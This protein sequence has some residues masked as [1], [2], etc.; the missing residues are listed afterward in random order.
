[1]GEHRLRGL[2]RAGL[3]FG[4][5]AALAQCPT[6]A[7]NALVKRHLVQPQNV[8]RRS[9]PNLFLTVLKQQTKNLYAKYSVQEEDQWR[10]GKPRAKLHQ[11][12]ESRKFD[13]IA[14]DRAKS[15]VKF[16]A[17]TKIPKKARL[18]QGN[19]NE[20][21]AYERPEEYA[22]MSKTLQA[23]GDTTFKHAGITFQFR[24]AGGMNHD[25]LSDQFT[26]W[27]SMPGKKLID[28]R[29]GSNWDATMQE[30][31]LISEARVYEMLRMCSAPR[32][33]DRCRGVLGKI[34]AKKN[35]I[36]RVV[37]QY[38]TRWKRL[39]GD[40]NTS[41]GNTIISM[42]IAFVVLTELPI[43]MRPTFVGAFFMGD[44]Y[45]A[46]MAF[47]SEPDA[48][49]LANA[50]NHGESAMGITPVR[51]IFRDP[52]KVTFIS[53]G[54]W[55]RFDGGYQFVPQ[56]AKQLTKLF[57]TVKRL[58][59]KEIPNYQS[60]IAVAFWPVFW[61]FPLMMKFL[62]AHYT[63]KNPRFDMQMFAGWTDHIY[64]KLT[65]TVRPVNW[66]AGMVYRYGLPYSATHLDCSFE[67]AAVYGSEVVQEMLRQENL[68]PNERP[69]AVG[70]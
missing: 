36:E 3:S 5:P 46:V 62:K 44:D 47:E 59:L 25:A 23:I 45:L 51:G 9:Y 33:L 29:D 61:G 69:S 54:V 68:D 2:C 12:D 4:L 56:P 41:V 1:M 52:Y 15:F 28:E 43:E 16:E 53:L 19:K 22:A 40:W 35:A 60:V 34:V 39:S 31:L 66:Q 11:I 48:Q 27:M 6:N 65:Q 38:A 14:S 30:S 10:V 42:I 7:W 58:E 70:H 17:N 49:E 24:Y 57:W 18:I 21:T 67:Q 50:L 64:N 13:R 20:A 32:F 37:V 26:E 63:V 55:P 8:G